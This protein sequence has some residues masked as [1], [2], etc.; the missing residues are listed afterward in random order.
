MKLVLKTATIILA[1]AVVFVS[2]NHDNNSDGILYRAENLTNRSRPEQV[3]KIM[4]AEPDSAFNR[5]ILG[6]PRFIQ[7]YYDKDSTECRFK[8]DRLLEVIVHKPLAKFSTA[9]LSVLGLPNEP[10]TAID[11]TAFIKW[12]HVYDGFNVITFYKVGTRPD[13]RK[14]QYK[15]YLKPGE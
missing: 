8:D 15:M 3:E 5:L 1:L 13:G 12:D 10:P 7:L 9:S 4:K 14:A 11:T 6:K 2:C